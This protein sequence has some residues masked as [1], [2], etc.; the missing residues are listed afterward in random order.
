MQQHM[1]ALTNAMY[2]L[3]NAQLWVSAIVASVVVGAPTVLSAVVLPVLAGT[4]AAVTWKGAAN[5]RSSPAVAG[6]SLASDSEGA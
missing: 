3:A 6:S 2:V 5:S 4:S 1:H